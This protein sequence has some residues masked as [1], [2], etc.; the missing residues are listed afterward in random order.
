MIPCPDVGA[1]L[2]FRATDHTQVSESASLPIEIASTSVSIGEDVD[3]WVDLQCPEME[4]ENGAPLLKICVQF[5][6]VPR[7]DKKK[8]E[9]E[10]S[11]AGVGE[12]AQPA[13]AGVWG[14]FNEFVPP[15]PGAG[16]WAGA[17]VGG[18]AQPPPPSA[19]PPSAPP[20]SS[21]GAGVGGPTPEQ[22]MRRQGSAMESSS[23]FFIDFDAVNRVI[24]TADYTP[25]RNLEAMKGKAVW[26]LPQEV[27]GNYVPLAVGW[28]RASGDYDKNHHHWEDTGISV[29]GGED[30]KDII[31]ACTKLNNDLLH[32]QWCEGV[33][34]CLK[35]L[36]YVQAS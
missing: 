21:S 31:A 2:L 7:A 34:V 24:N 20:A 30:L 28:N 23:P 15:P 32:P 19:P 16:D 25:M 29:Y 1:R 9:E 8:E 10:A 22:A 14:E 26:P 33:G 12:C 35:W 11:G 6:D 3:G 17:G 5:W 4:G 18:C 27:G 13:G 36:L